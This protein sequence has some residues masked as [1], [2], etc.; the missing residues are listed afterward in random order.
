V[1]YI[2]EF[3]ADNVELLQGDVRE[4]VPKLAETFDRIIMPLPHTASDFVD[5]LPAVSV[6][7]TKVHLYDFEDELGFIEKATAKV[8]AACASAGLKCEVLK[9]VKCGQFSPHRFRVC[10]DFRII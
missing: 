6:P 10:V 5:L 1:V 7:G 3:V 8:Q 9:V 2:R 4:L